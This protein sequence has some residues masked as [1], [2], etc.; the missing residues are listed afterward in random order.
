M[1]MF[2]PGTVTPESAGLAP[3]TGFNTLAYAATTNLDMA[4]L[5]QQYKTLTLTGDVTFTTSNLANGRRVSIRILPGASQRAFTFPVG[6]DFLGPTGTKPATIAANKTA[7]L[8]LTFYGSTDDDCVAA[9][10]VQG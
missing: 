6:W 8:S 7:V 5:D 3:A 2:I 1:S 4:A 10:S 9:Y